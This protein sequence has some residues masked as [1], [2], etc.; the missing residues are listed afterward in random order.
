MANSTLLPSISPMVTMET[1]ITNS[2]VSPPGSLSIDNLY[3]A[4]FQC[5]T[6]ILAGYIAGRADLITQSQGQGIGTFVGKFCLPALLFKSMVELN[7]SQVNWYFLL[8]IAISKTSVFVIVAVL[9]LLIRR[10]MHLGYAG[11]F[12]IFATQSNDFA[13]GYPILKALYSDSNPEYLQYIYLVAPISLVLLNPV[14]FTMLE[15]QRRNQDVSHRT[16]KCRLVL[17]VTK[18][19][20]SNPIVFMVLIGIGGNFLFKQKIPAVLGDILEVLGN[21]YSASALFYLGL[22][23]VGKVQGQLGVGLIAPMLLIGAK[24]LLLPLITWQVVGALELNQMNNSRSLSMYGFLYGTFPTAPSVFLY[25]SHFSVAQDIIATGMV[26][27]TFLSAPLMFVSAK[28]MTVVVNSEMDY[29]SLLVDTSFDLS[30][31][32]LVCNAW[33]IAVIFL[34]GKHKK[35]PHH[36]LICLVCTQTFACIGMIIYDGLDTKIAWQHYTQ[37]VIL[38]VGVFSSRC[39]AAVLSVVVYLLHYRSLCF[40]LRVKVWF[41]LFGLGLPVFST[42]MLLLLGKHHMHDE[43]DPSFHYGVDQAVLSVIILSICSVLNITFMVLHQRNSRQHKDQDGIKVRSKVKRSRH[44]GEE[45]SATDRLLQD[46]EI[47]TPCHTQS[48]SRTK[49]ISDTDG[50]GDNNRYRSLSCSACTEDCEVNLYKH[51]VRQNSSNIEDIVPFPDEMKQ[52]RPKQNRSNRVVS[53]ANTSK[54]N[55]ERDLPSPE[56]S[57]SSSTSEDSYLDSIQ[58]YECSNGTC[59]YQQRQQCAGLLRCYNAS[60]RN[61][62]VN[63]NDDVGVKVRRPKQTDE[64]QTGKFLILLLF[65]QVSMFMGLFICLWRLFNNSKSGIYV[66]IEFLDS[67]LNYGQSLVVFAIFGF[68]TRLMILPCI[69]RCKCSA[70]VRVVTRWRKWIYG[71]EMVHIPSR[72]ELTEEEKHQCD[73]FVKYHRENCQQ[74]IVR[75]MKY[76]FRTYNKVFCG[77]SFCDWMVEVGLCRG[78]GEAVTYGQT[79]LR[80]QIIGHVTS[81]HDFHDMPYFYR[82]LEDEE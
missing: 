45:E 56:S 69:K 5:F 8:G 14:G 53:K 48:S 41:Y 26:A 81:E 55:T 6:I 46:E 11:L 62:V 25:A 58:S 33:I 49:L 30:V 65:L 7:F 40:V 3:P 66:E 78:R 71:T 76:K 28:M 24:T 18:D 16:G 37:F 64:Y 9:T 10:P 13:L 19:V 43:I 47:P 23:L 27:G 57:V 20:L 21:A 36:F 82:F 1:N 44:R 51:T 63:D 54:A 68:D 31:I 22:S 4:I 70:G 74:D 12:A 39:F 72:T 59:S 42:G 79:L 34:S 38:I 35:M 80:G 52:N 2:T 77:T 73:Q 67:F 60:T 75:D 32:S 17:Q 29:K 15:I 50:G 61:I